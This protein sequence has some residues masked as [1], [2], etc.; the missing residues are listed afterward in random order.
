MQRGAQVC[1]Y[2]EGPPAEPLPPHYLRV[3]PW[4]MEQKHP[5]SWAKKKKWQVR[6]LRVA[7]IAYSLTRTLLH[8]TSC[9]SRPESPGQQGAY[10]KLGIII[11]LS[12]HLALPSYNPGGPPTPGTRAAPVTSAF[13]QSL[14]AWRSCGGFSESQGTLLWEMGGTPGCV[15][16]HLLPEMPSQRLKPMED[17]CD[18]WSALLM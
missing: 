9:L 10:C 1:R 7:S 11:T 17:R 15:P 5:P 3:L 2:P 6:A 12:E 4:E 16:T 13:S 8:E 18:R 14:P